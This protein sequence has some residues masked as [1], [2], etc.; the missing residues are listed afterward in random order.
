MG[1]QPALGNRADAPVAIPESLQDPG[2]VGPG[3][4]RQG[5]GDLVG[6]VVV[7]HAH[8]VGHP[9]VQ[10]FQPGEDWRWC[11]VDEDYV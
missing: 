5:P 3:L 11:Y 8:G 9:I 6:E 4:A 7:A 1:E 10:S 2:V